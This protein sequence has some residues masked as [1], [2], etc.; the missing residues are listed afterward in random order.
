MPSKLPTFHPGETVIRRILKAPATE[1]PTNIGLPPTHAA[2]IAAS[3][4]V[5]VGTLDERGRPWTTVWG[6]RRGFA[7]PLGEHVIGFGGEVDDE[8]DPVFAALRGKQDEEEESWE[9]EQEGNEYQDDEQEYQDFKRQHETDTGPRPAQ[10]KIMSALSIDL[11]TRDRIK[12][13]GTLVPGS[14]TTAHADS[15]AV[16]VAMTVTECLGNCPKYLNTKHVLEHSPAAARAVSCRAGRRLVLPVEALAL[17]SKADMFFLST[18]DGKT[19]DTNHRGGPPGFIRVVSND[20]DKGGVVLAYPEYSGNRLYQSL[21]NLCI[22]PRI[23]IVVPDYGSSDALYLTGTASI[24]VG[25]KASALLAQTTLAVRIRVT[26]ARFVC[27]GLPFRGNPG[28]P[29]PYTPRIRLLRTERG[30]EVGA[31]NEKSDG[32]IARLIHREAITPTIASLTFRLYWSGPPPMWQPGQ[33][34]TL[35][36]APELDK[37]YAH[38]RDDDPQSLNDDLIRTFTITNQAHTGQERLMQLTVRRHG[39]ATGLL[40][41]YQFDRPTPLHIPVLGFGG[42]AAFGLPINSSTTSSTP[43]PR[44]VF[45]AGGVGV[46]P[47]LS[48]AP[49]V[50]AASRDAT[51]LT[52]LWSLR[53]D[54]VNLAMHVFREIPALAPVTSLFVTSGLDHAQATALKDAGAVVAARRLEAADVLR[55]GD[56]PKFFLCAGPGLLKQLREWLHGQEVVWEDFGY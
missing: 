8:Y 27:A 48:Q 26:A 1:N 21:G 24:L 51:D 2:R 37:G 29:S 17:L 10:D 50:L 6:G 13:A 55:A 16:R 35:N 4:L 12:L 23:G 14:P 11:E 53:S 9:Q 43:A 39:P 41:D 31:V 32:V 5:A 18:T 47:L 56:K 46:T 45:V 28:E 25:A 30:D 33:H 3:P 52:V 38:M 49:A 36:F 42:K 22:N 54:D 40:C 7:K 20:A 34:A 15:H 44:S 19:M